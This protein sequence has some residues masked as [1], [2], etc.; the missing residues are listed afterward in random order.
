MKIAID[1]Q[2][3][4]S[5]ETAFRGIGRYSLGLASAVCRSGEQEIIPVLNRELGSRQAHIQAAL[6]LP[7]SR[8]RYLSHSPRRLAWDNAVERRIYS[9]LCNW[10][11][12]SEKFDLVHDSSIFEY[13]DPHIPC[14]YPASGE[15]IFS[16]TLYDLI[17][18]RMK[19]RYL[20]DAERLAWYMEYVHALERRDLLLAISETSRKDALELLDIREDQ[21][22]N[23]SSSV[24]FSRFYAGNFT[25]DEREAVLARYGIRRDFIL[26]TAGFDARKNMDGLI[27]AFASL[28]AEIRK[29]YQLVI[30]CEKPEAA[31]RMIAGWLR[32]AGISK[33]DEVIFTD[34][35]PDEDLRLLY[36]LTSLFVFPSLYEGFGLPILEAV[37]CG[38]PAIGS[39]SSSIA[40]ILD[41]P[42]LRFPPA[43]RDA[44]ARK[45]H[46][47]LTDE[48][49]RR[50]M[51]EYERK[52]M[53]RYS[54]ENVA[55]NAMDA[56][57]DA[58]KRRR[59]ESAV[60][61]SGAGLPEKK[62]RLAV[63]VPYSDPVS[64][65][66]VF[67][68]RMIDLLSPRY[69]FDIFTETD[70]AGLDRAVSDLRCSVFHH[71]VFPARSGIYAGVIY[72]FG[73]HPQHA[74][75]IP[76][77]KQ[78][79]GLVELHDF[80]IGHCMTLQPGDP[81][82]QL[83][84]EA[85]IEAVLKY[86]GL[87][88]H[89]EKSAWEYPYCH[90][91]FR[92]QPTVVLHSRY[93]CSLADRFFPQGY[94]AEVHLV[95]LPARVPPETGTSFREVWKVPEDA[96]VI[97]VPGFV[98]R[99]KK[100]ALIV[101][102]FAILSRLLAD[103]K[104]VLV[105]GGETVGEQVRA[106]ASVWN[107]VL[108][109]GYLPEDQY[110]AL[111]K[112]AGLVV[113]LRENDRGESSGTVMDALAAGCAVLADDHGV[114]G[115]FP[116]TLIRRVSGSCTA[117]ELAMAMRDAVLHPA[118]PDHAVRVREYLGRNFSEAAYTEAYA[119]AIE[120]VLQP[121]SRSLRRLCAEMVGDLKDG[122]SKRLSRL[123]SVLPHYE[124]RPNRQR[125]L[126]DIT[127]FVQ[128]DFRT[129]IQR[130]VSRITECLCAAKDPETVFLPVAL[131]GGTL[132]YCR[133]AASGDAYEY[134]A[135]WEA[136]PR[137]ILLLDSSWG[138][139]NLFLPI[140]RRVHDWGGVVYSVLYDIL[141][142]QRPELF[143]PDTLAIFRPWLK[144]A[145]EN[146]DGFVCISRSVAGEIRDYILE[147]HL[148]PPDKIFPVGYFLL[149]HDFCTSSD[150]PKGKSSRSEAAKVL[151][152]IQPGS[153]LLLS[154]GT[155]EP[156]KN[157]RFMLEVLDVLW[158]L[159]WSVTWVI[160][161]KPGWYMEHWMKEL[162]EHPEYGKR[163]F[164][165]PDTDDD[166]LAALYGEAEYLF[167]LSLGEGFGLPLIEAAA[168]GIPV[169]C[170]DIPVFREVGKDLSFTYC[171]LDSAEH[172]AGII[173]DLFEQREHVGSALETAPVRPFCWADS[174]EMLKACILNNHW[175]F[176]LH[177]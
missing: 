44:M 51:L 123:A 59:A 81:S 97:A 148:L 13:A 135:E 176:V 50:N 116:D 18:L 1:L 29:R 80:F 174:A 96:F 120:S 91:I 139:K 115:D 109:T 92:E 131:R 42:D 53:K 73:N 158:N 5:R 99:V 111:L 165:L 84:Q 25:E 98:N 167:Q 30:V 93:A 49:F 94:P 103:R 128:F 150:R 169:I 46:Q 57:K 107:S 162:R 67:T 159:D 47:A 114:F 160:A 65:I 153:R 127:M 113:A 28:P 146:T 38:A 52:Q 87:T 45:I 22:V 125:V 157:H 37:C 137:D 101:K 95:P 33:S 89:I 71:S 72:E 132:Y 24:D 61:V 39:D 86:P 20:P 78:Y 108:F 12:A 90:W 151:K 100:P 138:Y 161:G 10:F 122:D 83:A 121:G 76:Y 32:A 171:P 110:W 164:Y 64:G 74:F 85:G 133:P 173:K 105:F 19:D 149:G 130:V 21:V 3:C 63:F 17:P 177:E 163:I 7:Q 31:D 35:I 172:S 124:V 9:R 129:G 36:N 58:V 66:A 112:T 16:A 11:Y 23:I 54:W 140:I 145:V 82:E 27:A 175:E 14:F 136:L 147:N 106:D 126:V 41:R 8:F 118:G 79:P 170:S 154:V 155:V 26:Y 168:R 40:E 142:A 156:R 104:M 62:K 141:P 119:K 68:A 15:R 60:K 134:A 69:G 143:P 75:M 48:A 70:P 55:R 56:W 6:G 144:H 4:Q 117:E 77:M 152:K 34:R 102:A 166:D 88:P 43:D 2:V